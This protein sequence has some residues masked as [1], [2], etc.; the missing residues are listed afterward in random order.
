[1]GKW[2]CFVSF[3]AHVYETMHFIDLFL[4]VFTH[5]AVYSAASLTDIQ[6]S[7]IILTSSSQFA[8]GIIE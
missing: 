5:A 7:H 8:R 4:T 3:L 1:M 2:M 6:L